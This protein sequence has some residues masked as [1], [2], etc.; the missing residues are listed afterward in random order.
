MYNPNKL[1]ASLQSLNS[2]KFMVQLENESFTSH[3][4]NKIITIPI[5]TLTLKST[6]HKNQDIIDTQ[7]VLAKIYPDHTIWIRENLF[8]KYNAIV[9]KFIQDCNNYLENHA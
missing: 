7:G 5:V 1:V 9:A 8:P 6:Y 3:E 2:D 4:T